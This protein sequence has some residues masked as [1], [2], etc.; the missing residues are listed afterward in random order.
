[1][2]INIL[3]T[4]LKLFSDYFVKV[5]ND[6]YVSKIKGG[7]L[8]ISLSVFNIEITEEDDV[9]EQAYWL[10]INTKYKWR[11]YWVTSSLY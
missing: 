9:S 8:S 2:M 4:R 7:A 6:R 5:W 1:M 10:D 11:E 3:K